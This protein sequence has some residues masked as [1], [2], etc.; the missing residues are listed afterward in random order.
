MPGTKEGGVRAANTNKA[1]YG[2]DFYQ[3]IGKRGGAKGT[4]GGFYNNH[5][6]AVRAGKIGGTK[7]RRGKA[8]DGK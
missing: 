4:T 5:E 6:L 1:K 7:S 2:D 3:K 8:S